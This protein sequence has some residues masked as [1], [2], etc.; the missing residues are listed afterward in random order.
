MA[1]ILFDIHGAMGHI[2]P[3][4]KLATLLKN[5][6]HEVVYALPKDF[7]KVVEAKGFRAIKAMYP[8]LPTEIE[9][10]ITNGDFEADELSGMR[11]QL[12][13]IN[14]D[15]VMI[16]EQD[17]YKAIFYQ[18]LRYP[19]LLSQIMPDPARIKGIPPFTS[20]HL[21]T[22]SAFNHL[23]TE[24]LWIRKIWLRKVRFFCTF[25]FRQTALSRAISRVIKK[26]GLKLSKLAKFDRAIIFG[27]EGVPR[28]I[29]SAIDF[30]FP[31]S[32]SENVYR[33]GPLVDIF[34]E[35]KID[36]P[37]YK[38][39]LDR[40]ERLRNEKTGNVI[41][42]SMGTVSNYDIGRC[43]KFL[44]KIVKVAQWH[45]DDLFVLST[46]KFF[47]TSK[48]LPLPNNL[49]VFDIVPQVDLLQKCDIMVTHGG[50]NSITECIFCGVPM[51]VYPLSRNWDQPGN[52]A[53]VVYHNLGL[54]GRIERDSAKS[55]SD[56]ID[57]LKKDYGIYKQ[58]V[59][60]MKTR[61]EEKNQSTE[62]VTI[63]E[64]I[65]NSHAN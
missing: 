26:Y 59:L 44:T 15:L 5:A 25:H 11:E 19:I 28:I 24:I 45:P 17:S 58:N 16:D 6:G 34:R 8:L 46:G 62:V 54:R 65:I 21:P 20:Y 30:D 57:I 2:H 55:I 32:D 47:D 63:I 31:H 33:I 41:F 61:F 53:R 3:T 49:F 29:L 50:M 7:K 12:K 10:R 52:S 1:I 9:L 27:I 64:S 37:R 56:K 36:H 48:L 42:V 38:L 43:T 35:G 13:T 22:D 4:L 60:K 40:I 51:L 18:I 23:V 39:L 14:P